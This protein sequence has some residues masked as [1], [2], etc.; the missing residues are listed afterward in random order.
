[1]S[2]ITNFR[3]E[4]SDISP[5]SGSG[6]GVQELMNRVGARVRK[7]RELK[8]IPRRVLSERSGV[9]PRYLAQLESGEG[10]ISIGLLQKVAVALDHR[11]EWFVGDEDPWSSEALRIADMYRVA[12]AEQRQKAMHALNPVDPD[13]LRSKRICLIGLRGAGKSTLGS[14]VSQSLRV[15]FLE[16]NQEIEDHAGMAISEVMALYG[17]EG[18]RQLESQALSRVI[19]TYDTVILGAAGGIVTEPE[20]FN[21]LL[22]YFHTIW[23]KANPDEHMSRVLGQGDTRPMANNPEA[24]KQLSSILQSRIPLY[25]RAEA[26]L[27][28]SGRPL[29]KSADQLAQLIRDAGFLNEVAVPEVSRKHSR[30]SQD[31]QSH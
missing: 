16:L 9:S 28:T 22:A 30:S 20:T 27:D 15:P 8:G 19:S 23:I 3:G 7:T 21:T 17:H 31:V 2:E 12:T 10:N 4:V 1:M 26:Q 5:K 29:Q 13:E 11:I 18:F 25:E 24:M 6:D 14:M